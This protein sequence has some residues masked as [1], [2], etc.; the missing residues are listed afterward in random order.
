MKAKLHLLGVSVRHLAQLALLLAC[1]PVVLLAADRS[2]PRSNRTGAPVLDAKNQPINYSRAQLAASP[3]EAAGP[4]IAPPARLFAPAEAGQQPFWQYA[5]FGSGIGLSNIIISP[6]PTDG[7]APQVLIGGTSLDGFG[8][9][10]FWQAIQYNPTTG[11]YDQLFVSPIYSATIA[12]I[13]LANVLGDSKPEIVV[14]L[15][16]GRVFFYDFATKTALGS[17]STGKSGFLGL[18]LTD[19]DNNGYAELIVTTLND[20]FVYNSAGALLWQ[21][22]GAG[23]YDVVAG[24]MDN[25]AALEIA[26]TNGKVVDAATHAVQ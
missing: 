21:V 10:D 11:N 18:N 1:A 5:V 23:G 12:R 17:F 14:V 20:L 4:A 9:D 22:A 24:Q 3:N 25:D 8:A 15:S 16:D 2:N 7:S 6:T 19:L 26:G 13:D